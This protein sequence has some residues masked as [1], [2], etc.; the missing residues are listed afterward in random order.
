MSRARS[1][2]DE[3]DPATGVPIRIW[4]TDGRGRLWPFPILCIVCG[5][6][7]AAMQADVDL[8]LP[9]AYSEPGGCKE[10]AEWR[11][12]MEPPRKAGIVPHLFTKDETD[13]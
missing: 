1:V 2:L 6:K 12:E 8:E 10:G 5:R 7:V 9:A 13:S 11:P 3:K 4:R